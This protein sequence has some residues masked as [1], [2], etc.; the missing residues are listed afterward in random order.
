[1]ALRVLIVDD[2]ALARTLLA[3]VLEAAGHSVIEHD[4]AFGTTGLIQAEK[5]DAVVVDV[6]LPGL[7]G[8][9]LVEI[10][11]RR[12]GGKPPIFV[13]YS[14]MDQT[15]LVAAAEKVGA[16]GVLPKALIPRALALEFERIVASVA[17]RGTPEAA[18]KAAE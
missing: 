5:P 10:A 2:D 8:P 7:Q 11:S 13:L 14:G 6:T 4:A 18:R 1:M 15:E 16:A 9:R 3:R 12:A 17:A